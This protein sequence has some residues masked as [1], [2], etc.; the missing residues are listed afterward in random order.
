[1]IYQ[2]SGSTVAL[3]A[4]SMTSLMFRIANDPYPDIL[5]IRPEFDSVEPEIT[6][7]LDNNSTP[8]KNSC[9]LSWNRRMNYTDA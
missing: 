6:D 8:L 1:M 7:K 9:R 5:A 2:I 4:D 3:I